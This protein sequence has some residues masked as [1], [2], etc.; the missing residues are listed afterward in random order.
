MNEYQRLTSNVG[1]HAQYDYSYSNDSILSNAPEVEKCNN[2]ENE[3][4]YDGKL[5]DI[6]S[7]GL[8]LVYLLS[9]KSL[10]GKPNKEDGT[11]SDDKGISQYNHD[12]AKV[13]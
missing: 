5:A 11:P 7:L 12:K 3:T 6:Y 9:G 8:V 13:Y 1:T 4:I 10:V 2:G